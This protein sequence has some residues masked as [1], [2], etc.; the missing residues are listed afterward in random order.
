MDS[1]DLYLQ[2]NVAICCHLKIYHIAT[3]VSSLAILKA[4]EIAIATVAT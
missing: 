4:G 3:V 2:L 1:F